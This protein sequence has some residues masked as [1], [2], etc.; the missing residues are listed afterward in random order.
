MQIF[1]SKIKL[2]LRYTIFVFFF[3]NIFLHQYFALLRPKFLIFYTKFLLYIRPIF[4]TPK[5]IKNYLDTLLDASKIEITPLLFCRKYRGFWYWS[6]RNTGSIFYFFFPN[7]FR[8]FF[9]TALFF[10]II[11]GQLAAQANLVLR[12]FT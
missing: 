2:I 7:F 1:W 5:N 12:L 3:Y 10:L 9:R 4:F 6:L 8:I 11:L